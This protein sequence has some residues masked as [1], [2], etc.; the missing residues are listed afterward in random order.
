MAEAAEKFRAA[1]DAHRST[2]QWPIIGNTQAGQLAGVDDI[3]ASWKRPADRRRS[4]TE[5]VQ[6][7]ASMGSKLTSSSA[8]GTSWSG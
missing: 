6:A 1:V 2:S 3:R 5:S 8:A 7:M 4:L